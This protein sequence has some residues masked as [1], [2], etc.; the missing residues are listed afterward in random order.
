MSKI[1]CD[2]CGTSYPD[3]AS[4]CP[5]CGCVRH[6]ERRHRS[7]AEDET[8]E[9]GAY[10][11][12]KGGRFSKSNVRK[13]NR[14]GNVP[15]ATKANKVNKA[16]KAPVE[17]NRGEEAAANRGIT[18]A[19]IALLL[20]I[21]AVV[22]YIMLHFFV[23]ELFEVDKTDNN[24]DKGGVSDDANKDDPNEN[25]DPQEVECTA[26]NIELDEIPL[27]S[28]G[29]G[30]LLSVTLTPGNTTQ[31][32]AYKSLNPDVATV[33]DRGIVTAVSEGEAIIEITCGNQKA[34]CKVLCDFD[35][36]DDPSVDPPEDNPVVPP[37]S[38]DDFKLNREDFS[39]LRDD[40]E[41]TLY[42]GVIPVESIEWSSDNESVAVFKNGVVTAVG[43]GVTTV[44]AK[45]N[46]VT[47]KCIVRCYN[48]NTEN[49]DASDSM[50]E[51]GCR[52]TAT[53]VTISVGESFNLSILDKDGVAVQVTWI[54]D[55]GGCT[56]S[57]N[58]ITGAVSGR[59]TVYAVY[60]DHTYSCIVRVK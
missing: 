50:G 47:L 16:N 12:V 32:L 24:P 38:M 19:V 53:D 7:S 4:Q 18:I 57:G 29:S 45:Y 10:T 26:I 13:R 8:E 33:S 41:W 48:Q 60:N 37:V 23:P 56:I 21:V 55:D 39:L 6:M 52:I 31:K 35:E 20:A 5:I 59:T 30:Y 42:R 28:A 11:Y 25:K 27:K 9:Y 44:Y 36:E 46:D 34:Q 17:K 1:I 54:C 51:D 49:N 2:V 43:N 40:E 15:V 22:I 58:W 3:T 14:T